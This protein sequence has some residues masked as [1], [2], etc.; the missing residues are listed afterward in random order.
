LTDAGMIAFDERRVDREPSG[1][2]GLRH[3]ED[4]AR[5]AIVRRVDESRALR[6]EA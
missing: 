3:Q 1:L 5:G 6:F 2:R 4:D